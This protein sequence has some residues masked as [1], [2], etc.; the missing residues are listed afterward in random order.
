MFEDLKDYMESLGK[1]REMGPEVIYPAHGKVV[2]V[3]KLRIVSGT[4]KWHYYCA[5][6]PGSRFQDQ[7][8]R[9]PQE[10]ARV[11]N[12]VRDRELSF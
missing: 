2:E 7:L 8:L 6:L 10:P 1:I 11:T 12:L 5:D 9:Q 3:R 4:P